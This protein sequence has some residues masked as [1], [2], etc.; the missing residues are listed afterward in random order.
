MIMRHWHCFETT[1]TLLIYV[2]Q[3]VV[4]GNLFIIRCNV[5]VYDKQQ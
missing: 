4:V 3:S 1:I 2:K 5:F